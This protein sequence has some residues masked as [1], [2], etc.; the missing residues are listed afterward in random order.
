MACCTTNPELIEQMIEWLNCLKNGNATRRPPVGLAETFYEA[1]EPASVKRDRSTVL[2]GVI[3]VE[4]VHHASERR[5]G[6]GCRMA[7]AR[8]KAEQAQQAA[9]KAQSDA[10]KGRQKA[11][12][13]DP[14]FVQPGA[15]LP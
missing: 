2:Q 4:I 3:G 7:T 5:S 15:L 11:Y 10:D 1:E 9:V 13:Y 6:C 14:N 8:A 12:G